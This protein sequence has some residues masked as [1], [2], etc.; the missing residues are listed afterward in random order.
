MIDR[1]DSLAAALADIEGGTLGGASTIIVSYLWWNRIAPRDQDAY[2]E[3]A[4]RAG[5][6]L[7][8]DVAMSPHYVEVR[9]DA[10]PSLSSEH[11]T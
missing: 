8:A 10:G 7:H 5:V 1:R 4:E 9:D 6:R 2:R 11:P 3:R